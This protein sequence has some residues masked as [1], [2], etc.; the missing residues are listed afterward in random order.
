LGYLGLIRIIYECY[1]LTYQKFFANDRSKLE[2]YNKYGEGSWAIITGSTDGIG[3]GFAKYLASKGFNLVCI[4]RKKEKLEAK[5]KEIR[6]YA[7]GENIKIKNIVKDFTDGYKE[8]FYKDIEAEI[9]GLDISILVNNVGI[10][11]E[12]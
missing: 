8:E 6:E 2:L 12:D 7:K 11:I 4:S 1:N 9:K 5:E 3:L 10:L